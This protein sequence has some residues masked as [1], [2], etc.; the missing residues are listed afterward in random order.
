MP[1]RGGVAGTVD[2][3]VVRGAVL[4]D[5]DATVHGEP[6]IACQAVVTHDTDAGDHNIGLDRLSVGEGRC[7]AARAD[8]VDRGDRRGESE[9]DPVPPVQ[10]ETYVDAALAAGADAELVEVEG[11]HFVVID[12]GSA[13]WRT[14]LEVLDRLG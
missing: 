14:Q 5:E 3:G 9:P 7:G 12:P 13:A 11:D 6:G 4:V 8:A 2:R 1:E 10:S